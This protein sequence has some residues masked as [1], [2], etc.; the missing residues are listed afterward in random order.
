MLTLQNTSTATIKEVVLDSKL[1][2]YLAILDDKKF[3][4]ESLSV[5]QKYLEN[6]L[7]FFKNCTTIKIVR[8]DGWEW[9]EYH[10]CGFPVDSAVDVYTNGAF[11]GVRISR[12]GIKIGLHQHQKPVRWTA[13]FFP[14]DHA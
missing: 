3:N 8:G 13:Y 4:I 7:N 1:L 2:G 14:V 11:N 5:A 6:C 10:C 12:H 9:K